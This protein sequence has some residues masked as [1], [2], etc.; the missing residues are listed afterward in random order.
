MGLRSEC[1]IYPSYNKI[2]LVGLAA[3]APRLERGR[4]VAETLD[5]AL[6]HDRRLARAQAVVQRHGARGRAQH[7]GC[8][9]VQVLFVSLPI[10]FPKLKSVARLATA[11]LE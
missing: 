4:D 10:H 11:P 6:G 7:A 5:L 2:Y 9:A 3:E 1:C 8:C